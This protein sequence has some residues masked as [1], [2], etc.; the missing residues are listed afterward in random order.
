MKKLI[1][2]FLLVILLTALSVNSAFAVKN[3]GPV[4][5]GSW[6]FYASIYYWTNPSN[7]NYWY[8][9]KVITWQTGPYAL[10]YLGQGSGY[11]YASANGWNSNATRLSGKW[12]YNL[13]TNRSSR[14]NSYYVGAFYDWYYPVYNSHYH[15]YVRTW[16]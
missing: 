9:D 6:T 4:R 16:M 7:S 10:G 12:S 1:S 15:T 11:V 5:V 3:A 13:D 14:K 8:I 2:I